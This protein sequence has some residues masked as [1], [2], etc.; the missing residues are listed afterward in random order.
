MIVSST[1]SW[2][3]FQEKKDTNIDFSEQL[4]DLFGSKTLEEFDLKLEELLSVLENDCVE[5]AEIL[6]EEAQNY[7]ELFDLIDGVLTLRRCC[8]PRHFSQILK[9][10]ADR[11]KKELNF[12]G[13]AT[14]V[15]DIFENMKQ[16]SLDELHKSAFFSEEKV[17]MIQEK[18]T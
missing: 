17:R 14:Q 5:A 1:P 9:I 12:F 10:A 2:V 8:S 11:Q 18:I 6:K 13:L 15:A 3:R 16:S 4:K 7:Q